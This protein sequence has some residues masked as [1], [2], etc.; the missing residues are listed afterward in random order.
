MNDSTMSLLVSVALLAPLLGVALLMLLRGT[1]AAKYTAL[2]ATLLP[3]LAGIGATF[4]LMGGQPLTNDEGLLFSQTASW[5]STQ[6]VDIKFMIGIDGVSGFMMLL[7]VLLFPLLVAYQWRQEIPQERLFYGMLLLLETGILGF[8]LSLDLLMFYIFFELVLI[9]TAFLIGIWGHA[10]RQQAA[11]KFFLYTLAGSLLMLISILY[12]GLNAPGAEGASFTTDYFAIRE[13]LRSGNIAAFG[14]DAQRWIF[15]GFAISF[16][17]KVPL[18]P[19][20]TW[21][22]QTYSESSTTGSI[23]LAALLSKMGAYGFIRFCLPLFP[24]ISREMAPIIAG[25]AV[26]SILYGAYLAVVQSDLKRLIAFSSLSHLG[27]IVLGIFA[28]TPEALSGAIL[29]MF[30]HGVTTAGLFFMADMLERRYPSRQIADFQGVAKGAPAFTLLFMITIMASVGLPG[31]SGF[32]GEFMIL[33]G[34]FDSPTISSTFAVL[35]ALGVILAA[36]YLLNMFRK[37]MFGP[38]EGS[39]SGVIADTNR[40]EALIM[41]PLILLMFWVG[42]YATPFLD[43]IE[44][45][46]QAVM[47]QVAME[48][49]AVLPTDVAFEEAR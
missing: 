26:V 31:L 6:G 43:A 24:E 40:N 45:G 20:H 48:A 44:A 49:P 36:V 15:L 19:L 30:A 14:L 41:L 46:T 17:I 35:G 21:Q 23:V 4:A 37:V 33:T 8:F 39:P 18:F 42:L 5:F 32:V 47:Q 28:M 2:L 16:A 9:P 10:E 25:L 1:A 22:A 3:L 13:A 7:T 29:Q 34:S 12:L 38:A 11:L 27:F